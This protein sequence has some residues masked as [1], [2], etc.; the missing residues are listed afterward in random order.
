MI[1]AV[2]NKRDYKVYT[3]A[4]KHRYIR[5]MF[6]R[7]DLNHHK[8]YTA[9][10]L[11]LS[12]DI[13]GLKKNLSLQNACDEVALGTSC[14]CSGDCSKIAHCSCKAAGTFCTS[15][16]HSGRGKNK[17]CT[18]LKDY[19]ARKETMAVNMRSKFCK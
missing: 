8:N 15:L 11:N 12:T 17:K 5:G 3:V 18:L 4:S 2:N 7:D 13:E 10:I 1:T 19:V 6:V 14:N 16:C 9:Q